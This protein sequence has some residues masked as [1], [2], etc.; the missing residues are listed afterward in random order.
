MEGAAL[1]Q[2]GRG[3]NAVKG[4]CIAVR[5]AES[6]GELTKQQRRTLEGQAKKGDLTGAYKGLQSIYARND[7]ETGRLS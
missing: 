3:M 2:D 5:A 4:F 1:Y 6:R 7:R